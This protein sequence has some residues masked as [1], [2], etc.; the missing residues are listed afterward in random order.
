MIENIN[1]GFI[2][3]KIQRALLAQQ[4]L[5]LLRYILHVVPGNPKDKFVKYGWKV[6]NCPTD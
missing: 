2:S 3:E 4:E 1:S 5:T 6:S